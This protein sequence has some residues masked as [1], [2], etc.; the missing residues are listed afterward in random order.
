MVVSGIADL[1]RVGFVAVAWG[2][3]GT[4]GCAVSVVL[5]KHVGLGI[6]D[7]QR[8]R[9]ASLMSLAADDAG[10]PADPEFRSAPVA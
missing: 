2:A 4:G 1:F 3:V 8:F 9:F 6:T 5:H 7:E 10:M